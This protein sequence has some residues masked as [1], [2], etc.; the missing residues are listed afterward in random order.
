M[1]RKNIFAS[2]PPDSIPSVAL[3]PPPPRRGQDAP[4]VGAI[5]RLLSL[6]DERSDQAEEIHRQLA[7]GEH[8]V[9][10][11]PDLIDPSPI[12]DRIEDPN[13]PEEIQFREEIA[14]DGQKI[15]VLLRPHPD[16]PGR[17]LTV[18]GH[19]RIA[20][21]RAIGKAVLAI[22]KDLSY[23]EAL[24]EQGRENNARRDTS[25][26]ERALYAKRLRQAGLTDQLIATSLSVTRSLVTTTIT[27]ADNVPE[28]LI[29]S[30]GPAPAIGRP[31]W[32]ALAKAHTKDPKAWRVVAD[33]PAF[34]ALT[35]NDRFQTMLTR[36]LA[37]SQSPQP[38]ARTTRLTDEDGSYATLRRSSKG[39]LAITIATAATTRPDNLTFAD[40]IET[41]VASL[42]DDW[43][44][45]R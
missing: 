30:I 15:P 42:R 17:F 18:Y 10:I 39:D 38:T 13:A 44:A 7:T 41:R 20:A 26:I 23:Q 16:I 43:K 40:W 4:V 21:L 27:I 35:S 12:R 19:R 1:S 28:D 9:S 3:T 22:V 32:E 31:R 34:A 14:G 2:T 45:G 37:L 29:V 6:V 5:G 8:V 33:E 25:F 11:A 36:L 24:V